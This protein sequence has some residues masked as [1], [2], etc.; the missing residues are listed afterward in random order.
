MSKYPASIFRLCFGV[1]VLNLWYLHI[2]SGPCSLNPV[3]RSRLPIPVLFLRGSDF[4]EHRRSKDLVKTLRVRGGSDS[5]HENQEQEHVKENGVD[6]AK[7]KRRSEKKSKSVKG[8]NA[9]NY[10]SDSDK[11]KSDPRK[12]K[13]RSKP[14]SRMDWETWRK[15]PKGKSRYGTDIVAGSGPLK[16]QVGRPTSLPR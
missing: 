13:S 11:E 10:D 14:K 6:G 9:E 4:H 15:L 3:S 7:K 5:T 12:K 8:R 2:R 1:V 16:Y